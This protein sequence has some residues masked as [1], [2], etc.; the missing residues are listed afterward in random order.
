MAKLC[1]KFSNASIPI[2]SA[3]SEGRPQ[4]ALVRELESGKA[5]SAVQ[6]V[7]AH[8]IKRSASDLGTRKH[9]ALVAPHCPASGSR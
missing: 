7:A 8:W 6:R 9:S 1:I 5:D 4:D 3:I 2:S